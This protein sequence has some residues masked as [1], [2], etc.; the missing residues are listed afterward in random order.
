[1]I[2]KHGNRG[3]KY[4]KDNTVGKITEHKLKHDREKF[5]QCST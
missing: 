4:F 3:I 1:M 2:S 5:K